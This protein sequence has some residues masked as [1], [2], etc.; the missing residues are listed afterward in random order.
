[1]WGGDLTLY[2]S[3]LDRAHAVYQNALDK[4]VEDASAIPAQTAGDVFDAKEA[5]F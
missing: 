1:V 5:V 4:G 3:G 2:C